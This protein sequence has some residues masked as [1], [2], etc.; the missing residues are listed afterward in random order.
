MAI[1]SFKARQLLMMVLLLTI[2][3]T[4]FISYTP[5]VTVAAAINAT[6]EYTDAKEKDKEP[7]WLEGLFTSISELTKSIEDILSGKALQKWFESWLISLLD[8]LINP[9]VN[10][11]SKYMIDTPLIGPVGWV[12]KTWNL[13][14]FYALPLFGLATIPLGWR[15]WQ[16]KGGTGI[17][18][19]LSLFLKAAGGCILTLYFIDFVLVLK[20]Q[21]SSALA[22]VWL[23][24][25]Y[26]RLGQE[27]LPLKAAN[28]IMMLKAAMVDDPANM[29]AAVTLGT[30][31]YNEIGIGW[32]FLTNP[33]LLIIGLVM[34]LS[35]VLLTLLG[36]TSPAYFGIAVILNR[37]ESIAGWINLTVRTIFIPFLFLIA[38][39]V[40]VNVHTPT[41]STDIGVSPVFVSILVLSSALVLS[42][43]IWFKS[44]YKAV[45]SPLTL[46]GGEVIE[47]TGAGLSKMSEYSKLAAARMGFDRFE[48]A[49]NTAGEFGEKMKKAGAKMQ[50]YS[51]KVKPNMGTHGPLLDRSS[52]ILPEFKIG[53]KKENSNNNTEPTYWENEGD[54]NIGERSFK[55]YTVVPDHQEKIVEELKVEVDAKMSESIANNTFTVKLDNVDKADFTELIKKVQSTEAM[56][57]VP[58]A[59]DSEK[60]LFST[61]ATNAQAVSALRET[62]NNNLDYCKNNL[63]VRDGKI[64]VQEAFGAKAEKVMQDYFSDKKQYWKVGHEY[65]TIESGLPVRNPNPPANGVYMG[66]YKG[67]K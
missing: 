26:E 24:A 19:S 13:S 43:F 48:R 18:Q 59:F 40:C 35:W 31:F 42:Y 14:L 6:E 30:A 53:R 61:V 46:N 11:W 21:A 9:V 60:Q 7:S 16:A 65:L 10:I 34:L 49:S 33:L 22:Q 3:F 50:Q 67:R 56:Q 37:M 63:A 15:M 23:K 58:L 41:L 2:I 32:V 36:I 1:R 47:K 45:A 44:A 51:E 4:I 8:S 29:D 57:K 62:I 54:Q 27:P 55:T 64:Y 38:W 17:K 5:F 12:N 39:G 28:G 25:A 66:E 52:S 20:N